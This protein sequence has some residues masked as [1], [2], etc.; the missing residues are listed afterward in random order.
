MSVFSRTLDA[1][2]EDWMHIAFEEQLSKVKHT[3]S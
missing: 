1:G 3:L 2:K